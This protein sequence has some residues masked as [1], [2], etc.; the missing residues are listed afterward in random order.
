MQ[1]THEIESTLIHL[2][3]ICRDGQNGFDTAAKATKDTALRAELTQ[4]SMQRQGFAADLEAA[5]ESL[6]ESSDEDGSA[7]GALH[8]GWMNLKA[9]VVSNDRYAILA[10]CERGEDSA[11]KTYRQAMSTDLLP[12][13]ETLVE[14]QYDQVRRVHDRV[15]ELRDAARAK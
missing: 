14:S 6:G 11:V 3:Q 9:A 15:K 2:I 13:V 5:L 7:A 4:Y 8:R 1:T 10:E 12:T